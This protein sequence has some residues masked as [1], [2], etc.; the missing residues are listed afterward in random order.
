MAE[1]V[2]MPKSGY[3]M[4]EG[5]V[6]KVLAAEGQRVTKG[7]PLLEYETD[8][9]T[10]TVEAGQDGVVLRMLARE[11]ETYPVLTPLAVVGQEGEAF[12]LPDS[13]GGKS[14]A[15]AKQDE[16]PAPAP[17]CEPAPGRVLA[18]PCARRLAREN[19]VELSSVTGTGPNGRIQKK[20]VLGAVRARPAATHLAAKIAGQKG[21]SLDGLHGS[22]PRGRIEK[23]DLP[24]SPAGGAQAEE[25]R[26]KLSPMRRTI[27]ARLT[28][29]KQQIPHVYYT[30]EL[31]MDAVAQIRGSLAGR[32]EEKPTYNDFLLFAVSR[33]LGRFPLLTARLEEDEIVF[34]SQVNLGMAV[35]VE[36]GLVVPV[37]RDASA[38]SLTEISREASRLAQTAREKRLT[39]EEMSGGCFTVSNLGKYGLREFSA[40][41]NPP[42]A[43]ILAVGAVEDR[44]CVRDGAIAVQKAVTVTLSADHRLIDG[45]LA[46]EFLQELDRLV[47]EPWRMLL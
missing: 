8:K 15:A 28:Q 10:G 37:L 45:A 38:L 31:G 34:P 6:S 35:T 9:L 42:E 1:I 32:G 23:S 24:R 3:T 30:R 41:I 2:R 22:G 12:T 18:T 47:R 36:G 5:L 16:A 13:P 11:G 46:A 27:A 21:V 26:E 29:S 19:G 7:A 40:V 25:R 39:Q 20:D 43:A 17:V 4:R 44:P 33:A 14:P